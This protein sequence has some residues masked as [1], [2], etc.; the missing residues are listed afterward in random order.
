M[1]CIFSIKV[2]F[3]L[4]SPSFF[5]EYDIGFLILKQKLYFFPIAKD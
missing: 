5:Y 3:D 2:I 1:D 4:T